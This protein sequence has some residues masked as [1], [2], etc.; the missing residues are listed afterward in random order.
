M[1]TVWVGPHD[2]GAATDLCVGWGEVPTTFE[3]SK[4]KLA[5]QCLLTYWQPDQC[6][7]YSD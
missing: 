1:T 3:T 5:T 4:F 6:S 2:E 7:Q